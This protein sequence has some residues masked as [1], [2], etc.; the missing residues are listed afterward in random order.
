MFTGI[1]SCKEQ[2]LYGKFTVATDMWYE[3]SKSQFENLVYIHEANF[4]VSERWRPSGDL[5]KEVSKLH[6]SK[7][8]FHLHAHNFMLN[9]T[10]G[11]QKPK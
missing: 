9:G 2:Q 6:L 4:Y 1:A 8:L 7:G 3:Y 11:L 5:R 10:Q